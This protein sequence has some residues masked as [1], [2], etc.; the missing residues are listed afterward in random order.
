MSKGYLCFVLQSHL[1]YVRHPE[2]EKKLE[3][4]WFFNAISETYLPL[5][6][7]FD[8]LAGDG[9]RFK[10]AFSIS[11]TLIAMLEDELL[12]K[13]YL[14]HLSDKIILGEK[15]VLRT[16]DDPALNRLAQMY[17]DK[18]R[19]N[20]EDFSVQYRCNLIKPIK[21]LERNGYLELI[22][23]AATH[24]FLPF[25][26]EY[27]SSIEAQINTA[28]MNHSRVFG[29]V[30]KGF[31]LPELAYYPGLDRHLKRNNLDYF[32]TTAHSLLFSEKKTRYGVYAPMKSPAGTFAFARDIPASRAVWSEKDGYPGDQSYRDFYR[33]I[34]FE[35]PKEYVSP[36]IDEHELRINTGFKYHAISEKGN[37]RVYDREEALEVVEEH[38]D[39]FLYRRLSQVR[40][41]A[42]L[43]DRPPLVVCPYDS[44][45]FGR[46][47]FEGPVWLE[48]IIRKID[49]NPDL[50]L[51][52]P[53]DYLEIYPENDEGK[54]VYSSW[55]NSGYGQVWLNGQNDW[56]YR[57]IHK[58]VERMEDLV[59]RF[60]DEGGLKRRVLDQ[61][62]REV[63]L[64]QSSD[65]PFII[66]MGTCEP[67]AVT[68]VREHLNNFN[69]IYD[70]LC[71]NTVNTEWLTRLE[72]RHN[73]FPNLDYRIFKRFES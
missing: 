65:W 57:H 54:P 63:L 73:I 53:S 72:K 32:F 51:I 14:E 22:T 68:R 4:V 69:S 15:E 17:L 23:T 18:Y 11:A 2:S 49:E 21:N 34:G 9:I 31:W 10:L 24:A 35:L 25:Y 41:V 47:W 39:N 67:Y 42:N 70:N 59:H 8:R 36:F 33:D 3:E 43:I 61:A 26:Q 6:R 66:S 58:A 29:S 64:A 37:Q 7:V 12:Q 62:A 71:R 52:T 56:I 19:R 27:A 48:K 30:P 46:W 13:R 20:Y 60:P 40:K 16:K 5:L 38:A 28:V 45:L 1:P 44:E 55:G 50:S